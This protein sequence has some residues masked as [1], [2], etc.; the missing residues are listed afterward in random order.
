M[1]TVVVAR[2]Q[3]QTCG[4]GSGGSDWLLHG[5]RQQLLGGRHWQ[6]LAAVQQ[7]VSSAVGTPHEL[8]LQLLQGQLEAGGVQGVSG[9]EVVDEGEEGARLSDVRLLVQGA[10]GGC[11]I[12]LW[13]WLSVDAAADVEGCC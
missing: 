1:Q 9:L 4:G 13:L 5:Q 3:Q 2:A 7:H 10:A 12:R 6:R 8:L 11:A